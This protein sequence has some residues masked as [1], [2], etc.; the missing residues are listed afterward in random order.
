[1][2]LVD[3]IAASGRAVFEWSRPAWLAMVQW[4]RSS[5]P[6]IPAQ[7]RRRSMHRRDPPAWRFAA[8]QRG[9]VGLAALLVI[10]LPSTRLSNASA[11]R[12]FDPMR[13]TGDRAGAAK[14]YHRSTVPQ[15]R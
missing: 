12:G 9:R 10:Q 2:V 4:R 5:R 8:L 3:P 11:I 13:E 6:V 14:R 15:L 7:E 1:V